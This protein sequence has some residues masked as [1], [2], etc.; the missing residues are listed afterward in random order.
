LAASLVANAPCAPGFQPWNRANPQLKFDSGGNAAEGATFANIGVTTEVGTMKKMVSAIVLSL[1]VTSLPALAQTN[2]APGVSTPS[3]PNSGAGVS[4]YP[5]NK[6][7]P[8]AK[9]TVGSTTSTK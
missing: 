4:G 6:N 3:A 8:P 7:G 1:A 5:G 2:N 9:G